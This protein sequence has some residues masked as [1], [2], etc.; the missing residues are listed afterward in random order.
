MAD[1]HVEEPR[2]AKPPDAGAQ[3]PTVKLRCLPAPRRVARAPLR[4]IS[5]ADLTRVAALVAQHL[6]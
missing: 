1:E 5:L 3:E 2:T 6:D 4:R